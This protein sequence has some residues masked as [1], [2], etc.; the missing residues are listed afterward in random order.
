LPYLDQ[1]HKISGSVM[2]FFDIT[3]LKDANHL[4]SEKMLTP[5]AG[6]QP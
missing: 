4:K 5:S 2:T 3:M 1:A 6:E